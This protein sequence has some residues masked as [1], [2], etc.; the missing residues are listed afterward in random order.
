MKTKGKK[1]KVNIFKRIG[2]VVK[3][4]VKKAGKAILKLG[5]QIQSNKSDSYSRNLGAGGKLRGGM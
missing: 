5:K 3:K 1:K 4:K 2:K